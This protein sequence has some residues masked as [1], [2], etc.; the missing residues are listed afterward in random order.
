MKIAVVQTLYP[1]G[2]H[3][4]DEGFVRILA[5]E[6]ELCIVDDGKYFPKSVFEKF[7]IERIIVPHF[8][9]KRWEALKRILRRIDLIFVFLAIKVH[10]F[11]YDIILFLNFDNDIYKI[12][13][14]LPNKKKILIH[15]NDIDVL[16]SSNESVRQGFD[17][18][19][20]KFIHVCL[21][22]YISDA[23][24]S[25]AHLRDDKVFTVHQPLVFKPNKTIVKEEFVVGIGNSM[26]ERY[27][28]ELVSLDKTCSLPCKLILRSRLTN[29]IGRNMVIITGFLER[30]KYEELYNKSKASLVTYPLSYKF[31]YSGIIDDSLSMGLVVFSNDTLCGRY[32][33]SLYPDSVFI[34]DDVKEFWSK[35]RK[36]LPSQSKKDNLLFYERH[37]DDYVARQFNNA[38]YS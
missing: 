15:H 7:N 38:I 25:Y 9:I 24:K 33:A 3:S 37:S 35:L 16:T 27:I 36:G 20:D 22:D 26:D 32:F 2:H 1:I 18:A 14:W 13:R 10:R 28:N 30:S 5:K 34:I 17:K 6:H 11:N 21:A 19:K 31:R 4:L 8:T 23:F 12:E 29:Y